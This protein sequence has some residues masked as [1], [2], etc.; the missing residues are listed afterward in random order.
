VLGMVPSDTATYAPPRPNVIGTLSIADDVGAAATGAGAGVE[1]TTGVAGVVRRNTPV[2]L[3]VVA[4]C[5]EQPV[6]IF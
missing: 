6:P 2:P 5:D 3:A 4:P 1:A